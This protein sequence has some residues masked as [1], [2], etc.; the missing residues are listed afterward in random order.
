MGKFVITSTDS[1]IRFNLKASNGGM[2]ASSGTYTAVASCIKGINSVKKSCIGSVED[3]TVV[4][5]MPMKHPKFELYSPAPGD[6]RF[7]LRSRNGEILIVSEKYTS[8]AS[9]INGIQS[10]KNNAPDAK[11]V[12]SEVSFCSN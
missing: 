3:Q 10:V 5:C 12:E 1:G 4:G 8:K 11:I 7:R 6:F 9:C 2:L